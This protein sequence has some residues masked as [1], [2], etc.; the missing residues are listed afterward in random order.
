MVAVDIKTTTGRVLSQFGT[1][2]LLVLKNIRRW[3][4]S[5]M[6]SVDGDIEERRKRGGRNPHGSPLLQ[7]KALLRSL[8]SGRHP[9][10]VAT[11]HQ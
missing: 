2:V 7:E 1:I 3:Q 4:Y 11:I 9:A 5:L 8:P 6:S 10:L